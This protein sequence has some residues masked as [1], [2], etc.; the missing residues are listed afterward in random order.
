MFLLLLLLDKTN[1]ISMS[2]L[3]IEKYIFVL[4]QVESL[5]HNQNDQYL[6]EPSLLDSIG[7]MTRQLI[8]NNTIK[9]LI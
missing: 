2:P 4:R 1:L 8:V 9:V 3:S 5:L 7:S 6:S